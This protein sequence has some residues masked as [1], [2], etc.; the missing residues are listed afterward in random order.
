[1]E[2]ENIREILG[3]ATIVDEL[4]QYLSTEELDVFCEHLVFMY[5]LNYEEE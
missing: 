5:D 1:M 2:I 3:D 4:I